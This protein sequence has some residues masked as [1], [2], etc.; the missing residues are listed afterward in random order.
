MMTFFK[1]ILVGLSFFVL[2]KEYRHVKLLDKLKES[3]KNNQRELSFILRCGH[4]MTYSELKTFI[5]YASDSVNYQKDI[6]KII[7][8]YDKL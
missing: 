6:D 2:L 1:L 7:A 4:L 3:L 8:K 5:N